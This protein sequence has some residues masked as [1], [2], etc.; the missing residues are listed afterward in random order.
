MAIGSGA[1]ATF[2][3]SVAFGAGVQTLAANQFMFGHATNIYTMPGLTSQES[4]DAQSGSLAFVTVDANGNLATDGGATAAALQDSIDMNVALLDAQIDQNA[5]DISGLETSLDAQDTRLLAVE[6][7]VGTNTTA[8][9]ERQK[10][11]EHNA[12]QIDINAADIALINAG[13]NGDGSRFVELEDNVE[14]Q[15][16][17]VSVVETNVTNNTTAITALTSTV[18]INQQRIAHSEQSIADNAAAISVMQTNLEQLEL[19]V[20]A[21]AIQLARTREEIDENTAGIAIANALSGSTWL[22]SNEKVA[23][24]ANIGYYDGSTAIAF[25]GATRLNKHISA[26]VALG[27]VPSRG[28]VGAR[29]G[30][31]VGW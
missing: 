2:A 15:A 18:N 29:A 9:T 4:R 28:D 10:E 12:R 8:L 17:R 27:L 19:N 3:N 31:R 1:E 5:T 21:V 23:F 30:V 25:S 11:I 22:Q 14:V 20:D 26:N 6:T 13:V 7:S 24:S 16:E